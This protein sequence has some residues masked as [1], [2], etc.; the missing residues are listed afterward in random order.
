[1]VEVPGTPQLQPGEILGAKFRVGPVIGRGGM[2]VVYQA[3]HV[4]LGQ[5]VA[6][7]VLGTPGKETRRAF[8]RA[9]VE[10][11]ATARLTSEHVVRVFDV[12]M[13][14]RGHAYVVMEKLAGDDVA[15]A[16]RKGPTALS[17]A[18][19]IVLQACHALAEAHASGIVHRDIK[20]SNLFLATGPDRTI[21]VKVLDFGLARA[22]SRFS[23]TSKA[24]EAVLAMPR[25]VGSPGYAS[26]EQLSTAGDVDARADIWGLGVVL[27]E[28]VTG[29]RP[30]E[31]GNLADALIAAITV[32]MPPMGTAERPVPAAFEAIV[33]R[34]LEKDRENR[35]AEVPDLADALVPFAPPAFAHYAHRIRDVSTRKGASSAATLRMILPGDHRSSAATGSLSGEM[36]I[37][38][39]VE[40]SASTK[41]PVTE[42]G[43]ANPLVVASP[44]RLGRSAA[45][46]VIGGIVLGALLV[47]AV[48][49]R[50][51]GAV[52]AAPD[53]GAAFASTSPPSALSSQLGPLPPL[54]GLPASDTSTA[55]ASAPSPPTSVS[56]AMREPL[57][58]PPSPPGVRSKRPRTPV[59]PRVSIGSP[60]T[61]KAAPSGNPMTYR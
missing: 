1:M 10:A 47:I 23:T 48:A 18:V 19:A 36:S 52:S 33:R 12:G 6:V 11:Q 37:D 20:P 5:D 58:P 8:E 51:G 35:F 38:A 61:T 22:D 46:L 15:R 17:D 60:A 50:G 4:Q 26:P 59:I 24:A 16:L 53:G 21:V 3:Q 39:S 32:P 34:C 13:T 9:L 44:V 40:L 27:Y 42:V 43:V 45:R 28:L 29:R 2:S 54:A 56:S 57:S 55:V 25:V 41:E 49:G 30:F 14:D 31:A 7:K